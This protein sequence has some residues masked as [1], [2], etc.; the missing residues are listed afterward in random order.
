MID[1]FGHFISPQSEEIESTISSV[2]HDRAGVVRDIDVESGMH[3]LIRVIRSRVF[4][5]RDLVAKL[6]GIT[7]RCLHA[8]VCDEPDDDELMDAVFLELQIQI[9]V[10]EAAGTPVLEGHDL[11]RLR[12]EFA[13]D[14]AAPRPVFEDLARPGR[15][16]GSARCTSRSRSR[17]DGSD[18][19]AHR[20]REAATS[21]PHSEPAT[22]EEHNHW[23]L[24]QP[25]MRSQTLPPSEM[26][27]L[28]GSITRSRSELLVVGYFRHRVFS[29]SSGAARS[30]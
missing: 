15:S 30:R 11:A 20:R 29:V 12:R 14:L 13:A 8:R 5:H 4:Y 24:Q 3:F 16:S 6:S 23:L 10:G 17:R 9:R 2:D 25:S 26:K 27:S 22:Y 7:N 18:D 1:V 19:A 21:A 28:Y